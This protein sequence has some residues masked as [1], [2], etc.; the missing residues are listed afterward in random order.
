M[1]QVG[2]TIP[3]Y[4]FSYVPYSKDLE[5]HAVC[6]V[7]IKLNTDEWKG[8]VVVLVSVPGAF[9]PG[10]HVT[11]VP[12][13]VARAKEIKAKG[14]DVIA[15]VAANDPFV[16][17]AWGRVVGAQEDI[18]FLSDP[19]AEFASKLGLS[20]D[21]SAHG[22]GLRTGRFAIVIDDLKVKYIGHDA[23]EIKASTA[24][25]VL[26]NFPFHSPL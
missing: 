23:G 15:F 14:I 4:S 8:K 25:A 17:S 5:D 1:V 26:N 24:D 19:N 18:I 16:M 13:Y 22:F 9:T 2:D 3:S 11:H 20:L 7:P 10:C 6:G 12:P 21:L